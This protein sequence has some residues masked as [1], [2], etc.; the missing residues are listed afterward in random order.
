[1]I[2]ATCLRGTVV[3]LSMNDFDESDKPLIKEDSGIST[4]VITDPDLSSSAQSTSSNLHEESNEK[5]YDLNRMEDISELVRTRDEH[6]IKKNV[7]SHIDNILNEYTFLRDFNCLFILD[8]VNSIT[9][10]HAE[11]V[12]A[13]IQEFNDSKNIVLFLRSSGGS[14]EAAYLIS[15][16]CNRFKKDKFVVSIPAEAKSAATLLSFGADEIHMGPMSELGPIDI[17]VDGLPLLS[18][19]SALTKIAS[20]VQEYPKSASMFA[21]YLT[22]NLNIGLIGHYD[23]VTKSATQYAQMLLQGK[24]D[25]NSRTVEDIANHFTNHY[26]DHGFVI[27]VKESRSV[28]GSNMVKDN[29]E[30]YMVGSKI[31]SFI[32]NVEFSFL[33]QGVKTNIVVVGSG[34]E[35]MMDSSNNDEVLLSGVR[36]LC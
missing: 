26:K 6:L 15:Q 33:L 23:R 17:Q 31:L 4:D 19:S 35:I 32:N 13:A 18:V 16:L 1:M 27:D 8:E 2:I 28:L 9:R 29:T 20:I 3:E 22:K 10:V 11:R 34:C 5:K 7:K 12:Y 30:L 36:G 25:E 14:A 24:S 21:E